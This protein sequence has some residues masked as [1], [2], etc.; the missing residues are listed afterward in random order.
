[1]AT[2]SKSRRKPPSKRPIQAPKKK[3][4][5]RRGPRWL[6]PLV[7]GLLIAG[8]AAGAFLLA[9]DQAHSG[10]EGPAVATGGLPNTP[11]YHSL[12]VEP[13]NPE[14][15]LLGTHAGLYESTDG[16]R[17]WERVALEGQDAMNLA[18]SEGKT[19][20]TAGHN[21]FARSTDGG[22]TWTDLRPEGLPSLDIHGFAVDPNDS[23][24]LYAAVAGEGLYRST[25]G[26]RRFEL[27]SSEVGGQVFGLAVL[28]GGSILA[29]DLGKGLLRSDDGGKNWDVTEAFGAAG[30]AV[31][32][33]DPETVLAAG[34]GGLLSGVLLS[35]DGGRTWDQV[36]T[37]EQGAGP[38]A[39]APSEPDVG[40]AVGFDRTLYRT[41]DG[42]QSWQP[43]V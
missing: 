38:V 1:M 19:V 26:A 20:W 6:W 9:K 22:A 28:E 30:L 34:Q 12:L 21:V 37:I 39:W 8:I 7:T 16:G 11:D 17:D 24:T 36:H 25:D 14:H 10:G 43:V 2:K 15:V 18:R 33:D 32:P 5:A 31:K 23:Q 41:D 35:R 27:L 29:G 3:V 40:Y 4:E 42:G 13:S